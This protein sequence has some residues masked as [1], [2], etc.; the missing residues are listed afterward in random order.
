MAAASPSNAPDGGESASDAESIC[1]DDAHSA[2]SSSGLDSDEEFGVGCESR[3]ASES[4]ASDQDEHSAADES[5]DDVAD[6]EADAADEEALNEC[7]HLPL[8]RRTGLGDLDQI[9]R[10]LQRVWGS[11]RRRPRGGCRIGGG[12][13]RGCSW[14]GWGSG[15]CSRERRAQNARCLS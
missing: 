13:V 3:E 1:S 11:G 4:D 2:V 7:G 9:E 10:W 14:V 8:E 15:G 6:D 5:A 12:R